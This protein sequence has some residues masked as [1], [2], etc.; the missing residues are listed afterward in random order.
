MKVYGIIVESENPKLRIPFMVSRAI[1]DLRFAYKDAKA[2]VEVL[3]MTA[4]IGTL[5]I[6]PKKQYVISSLSEVKTDEWEEYNVEFDDIE[7]KDFE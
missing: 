2:Q 3:G 5:D 7:N 6:K 1:D 4:K